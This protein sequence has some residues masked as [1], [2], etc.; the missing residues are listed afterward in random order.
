MGK[1]FYSVLDIDP[2]TDKSEIDREAYIRLACQCYL[3][4]SKDPDARERF[5][6]INMAYKVLSDEET[7]IF[8][9]LYY[10]EAQDASG[11]QELLLC[12]KRYAL[13]LSISILT[14]G[15]SMWICLLIWLLV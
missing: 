7:R 13:A 1:G 12:W 11:Y 14:L 2:D 10:R 4:V 6:E 8:Y 9:N 5:E 3:D 15:V